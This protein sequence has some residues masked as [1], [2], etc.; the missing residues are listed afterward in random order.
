MIGCGCP[1]CTS[2]DPHNNRT[3]SSVLI[4]V[5]GANILIDTTPELR[6]Q[7]IRENVS[8]VDA[9]FFTH[10]HADHIFGL[11]DIR[12]FNDLMG[13][14]IPCYGSEETLAIVCQAFEYAFIPTQIGGGKPV[15]H[16]IAVDAEF[17][18][19]GVRI[20][21]VPVRHGSVRVLG[22]RIGD[23]AYVTDCSTYR[24]NL[25]NCCW[26]WIRWCWGCCG[27]SRMRRIFR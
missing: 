27:E 5:N 3:R 16:L 2:N 18:A 26:D 1:V 7:A 6:L 10:A 11:D 22:Y 14:P 25:S 23:F 4:E 19:C 21:P 17:E 9:V 13:G 12:R 24:G 8:R 20:Q 15:M